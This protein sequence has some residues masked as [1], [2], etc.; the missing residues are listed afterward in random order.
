MRPDVI[1]AARPTRLAAGRFVSEAGETLAR[2]RK[3]P[4]ISALCLRARRPRA[5][6]GR[7]RGD[8][9]GLWP[10]PRERSWIPGRRRVLWTQGR[11]LPSG[12]LSLHL[13]AD[14]I[15]APFRHI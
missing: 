1:S 10:C 8:A 13:P 7:W 2:R 14:K 9:G 5:T 15:F 6:P 11:N 12:L 3:N 4:E